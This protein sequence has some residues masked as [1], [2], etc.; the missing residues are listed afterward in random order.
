M[1]N[2]V[3]KWTWLFFAVLGVGLIATPLLACSVPV[4]RYALDRWAVDPYE[5][6]VFHRGELTADQQKIVDNLG[7]KGL[8]GKQFANIDVLTV[9]LDSEPQEELIELWK[10]QKQETLPWTLIMYPRKARVPIDPETKFPVSA[11]SA[12]LSEVAVDKLIQSPTRQEIARRILKGD[13]AVWLF[14]G[15]GDKAKDDAPFALL[16]KKVAELQ[17]SLK[18]P[19]IEKADIDQG[20]VLFDPAELKLKFSV[21]RISR[22]D[23]AEKELVEMLLGTEE[24][25]KRG[26]T[27]KDIDQ[28]MVFPMFGRGRALYALVGK[29]INDDTIGQ[30]GADLTGPCTCTIK[31]QNPGTDILMAVNWEALVAP[32]AEVDK[33]LPPLVG[34]G[35]FDET[36]DDTSAAAPVPDSVVAATELPAETVAAVPATPPSSS[37][38]SIGREPNL[39]VR[40]MLIVGVLGV[41]VVVTGSFFL[42]TKKDS[43]G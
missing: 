40:N 20:L 1:R 34:L 21:L 30:A 24:G 10:A 33:E 43:V 3:R 8:A 19:E 41:V 22:K 23:A 28:P 15:T 11:M 39:L 38:P 6:I 14:L 16:S 9:D 26:E 32:Q 29:G 36:V 31:E 42:S 25:F 18:L 12:P 13:S 7:H 2:P 35:G 17:K 37:S 4:F 5:A 27:L